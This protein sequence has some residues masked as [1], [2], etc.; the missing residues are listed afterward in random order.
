MHTK[1]MHRP[2]GSVYR[3]PDSPYWYIAY[4][5]NGRKIRENTHLLKH[6]AA[7][8]LLDSRLGAVANGDVLPVDV[9]K[10]TV[11][12]LLELVRTD[13]NVNTLKS[14]DTALRRIHLHLAP[15]F[16]VVSDQDGKYA[17]G[18]KATQVTSDLI[19]RYVV[20]RQQA[21]A[22]NGTVNRELSVLRRGFSLAMM[23]TPPKVLRCPNFPRLK[24]SAPRKGFL[25]DSQY[26][27]IAQACPELWFRSMVEVARTYGWRSAELKQLRCEQVDLAS[28]TIRL[29]AGSTKNDDGRLVVMTD[30]V[31]TLL[32]ECVRGK[33]GD[34]YVFTR[35]NGKPVRDFRTTW[36]RACV[37]AGV[38][39]W[40][41]P[42]CEGQQ[43]LNAGQCP[44]CKRAWEVHER[45]YAGAIFHDWRR[46]GV[47][48]MVRR[49]IPE[50]VA[51]T[52]SGH[53]TRSVFDR[54]NI[55]SEADLRD[56]ARKMNEPIPGGTELSPVSVTVTPYTSIRTVN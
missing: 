19:N 34:A 55:T 14:L 5:A 53:R 33:K 13:Y 39:R 50:R 37:A 26:H 18:M 30:A 17:S 40:I 27:A 52:I 1:R 49:G 42:A 15:F 25:E 8:K 54:Y 51:M 6:K 56:A 29:N 46:T 2:R 32:S 35:R 44:G 24:E 3:R 7:K 47:R 31:H 22:S 45:R 9:G 16:Y 48:A 41:C 10:T 21:G 43:V 12:E 20:A 23:A 11:G 36:R 38:G 28:R 4:S